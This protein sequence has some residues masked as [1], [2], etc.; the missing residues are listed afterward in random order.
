MPRRRRGDLGYVLLEIIGS[1]SLSL[2]LS[3]FRPYF[4]AMLN[5]K[6]PRNYLGLSA[7]EPRRYGAVQLKRRRRRCS[8]TIRAA[9]FPSCKHCRSTLYTLRRRPKKYVNVGTFCD[10]SHHAMARRTANKLFGQHKNSQRYTSL[11]RGP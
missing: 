8:M 3:L 7:L 10:L 5:S 2:S 9:V 6:L 4:D 11:L 1:C